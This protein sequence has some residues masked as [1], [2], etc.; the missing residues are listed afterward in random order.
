RR[1]GPVREGVQ[2]R[3]PG[4]HRG[5]GPVRGTR[6]A[7][8]ADRDRRA[9]LGRLCPQG[10]GVPGGVRMSTT[11]PRTLS[12]LDSLEAE[13]VHI[14]REVASALERPVLLCSGGK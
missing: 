4:V 14:M 7:R 2:R 11:A 6:G 10:L 12:H 9:L 8:V 1:E 3:A 5:L 13:A